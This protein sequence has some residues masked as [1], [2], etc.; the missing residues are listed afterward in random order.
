[1]PLQNSCKAVISTLAKTSVKTIIFSSLKGLSAYAAE[2][3]PLINLLGAAVHIPPGSS[4]AINVGV[5]RIVLWSAVSLWA[6][7]RDSF[8]ARTV[9]S[10]IKFSFSSLHSN[11]E[12][13]IMSQKS[14]AA[15]LTSWVWKLLEDGI[16]FLRISNKIV[17]FNTGIKLYQE[18]KS[19]R[20]SKSGWIVSWI[21]SRFR[22]EKEGTVFS[23]SWVFE[24]SNLW[25]ESNTTPKILEFFPLKCVR[26]ICSP[27]NNL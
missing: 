17:E 24:V 16:F 5:E 6:W 13:G 20:F 2:V 11:Q 27:Y 7:S 25:P 9:R 22:E 23:V 3:L 10:K 1:M 4:P 19:F 21:T 14:E 26:L 18:T 12:I 8:P 15:M